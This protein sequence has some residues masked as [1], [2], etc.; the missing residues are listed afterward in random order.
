MPKKRA[1]HRWKKTPF[2]KLS[3]KP[4]EN[5]LVLLVRFL[6]EYAVEIVFAVALIFGVV[7]FFRWDPVRKDRAE[8]APLMES[9][10]QEKQYA[11]SQKYIYGYRLVG[12]QDEKIVLLDWDTLDKEFQAD[13]KHAKIFKIDN[14]EIYIRLPAV[15][16]SPAQFSISQLEIAL[17]K[18]ARSTVSL[19]RLDGAELVGEIL[20]EQGNKMLCLF[21][22][23]TIGF[24]PFDLPQPSSIK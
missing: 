13:W 17:P 18:G 11:L 23:R 16:Y 22:F 7:T 21:S 3:P 19:A 5:S 15:Y 10:N 14:E 24:P 6:L 2:L 1:K 20:E 4:K 8:F 12:I 9:L